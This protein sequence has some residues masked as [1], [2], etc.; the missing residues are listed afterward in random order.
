MDQLPERQTTKQQPQEGSL[1]LYIAGDTL[2]H[3][4]IGTG[5]MTSAFQI[6]PMEFRVTQAINQSRQA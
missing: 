3:Q 2:C 4:P 5:H 1:V 6:H